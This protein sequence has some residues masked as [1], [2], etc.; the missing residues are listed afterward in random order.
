MCVAIIAEGIGCGCLFWVEVVY[1]ESNAART[2]ACGESFVASIGSSY[3][4]VA[5][6]G[7]V[8][9]HAEVNSEVSFGSEE[10][11]GAYLSSRGDGLLSDER[12]L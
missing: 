10:G 6:M 3:L 9:K 11:S 4:Q 1:T 5:L 8:H 7:V 2:D 12:M